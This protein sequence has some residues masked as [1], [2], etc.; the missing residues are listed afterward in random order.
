MLM[1]LS[2]ILLSPRPI[3]PLVFTVRNLLALLY[4]L[5]FPT[6]GYYLILINVMLFYLAPID[7]TEL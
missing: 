4:V 3:H 2:F 5:R 1:T 7:A 6:T